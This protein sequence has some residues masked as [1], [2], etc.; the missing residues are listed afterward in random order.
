MKKLRKKSRK[1]IKRLAKAGFPPTWT[2]HALNQH[3]KS[4]DHN[5]EQLIWQLKHGGG[6][7]NIH[8]IDT[9]RA[10]EASYL[11]CCAYTR[12]LTDVEYELTP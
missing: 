7:K 6:L 1:S 12:A 10:L 8:L 4:F 5:A 3:K 11:V 2:E 9:I